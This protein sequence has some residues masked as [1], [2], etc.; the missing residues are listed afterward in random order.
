MLRRDVKDYMKWCNICLASKI[1]RHKPYGDL[2]SLLVPTHYWKNLSIDFVTSLSILTNYKGD[3]YDSI[4]VII[5][6]LTKMVYYKP[7]KVTIHTPGH[8]EIIIN[9]IVRYY[10]LPDLI[11]IN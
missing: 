2:Q 6:W 5:D 4:L 8:S 7:V 1:V 10:G 3:N 9:M 11:V